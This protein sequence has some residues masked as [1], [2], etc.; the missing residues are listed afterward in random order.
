MFEYIAGA[1]GIEEVDPS[2]PLV[3]KYRNAAYDFTEDSGILI[4][5]LEGRRAFS[6]ETTV[7]DFNG[8]ISQLVKD[9]S[10]TGQVY[11]AGK[12]S[13]TD[14]AIYRVKIDT[15]G[16]VETAT[17]KVSDDA[18]RTWMTELITTYNYYTA[19]VGG[20]M[21]RFDGTF[22][23]NDEWEVEVFGG[24]DEVTGPTI[25]NIRLIR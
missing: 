15:A 16:A 21:I 11:I 6:W 24:P 9:S 17:Y 25:T 3:L 20:I 12:S 22:V 18:G 4:D 2:N 23:L 13:T 10:S 19:L 8:R 5:Y 14:H 1:L 7:D